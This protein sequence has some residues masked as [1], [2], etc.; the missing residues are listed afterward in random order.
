MSKPH[1]RL[2]CSLSVSASVSVSVSVCLSLHVSAVCHR[3]VQL[4]AVTTDWRVAAS[5][6]SRNPRVFFA[7]FGATPSHARDKQ[8]SQNW[9]G[10]RRQRLGMTVSHLPGVWGNVCSVLLMLNARCVR[11][12]YRRGYDT[13]TERRP[14]QLIT[15]ISR[16]SGDQR[17]THITGHNRSESVRRSEWR[18]A[19]SC[20]WWRRMDV[21]HAYTQARPHYNLLKRTRCNRRNSA[22]DETP[23]HSICCEFVVQHAVEQ[24]ARQIESLSTANL[25]QVVQHFTLTRDSRLSCGENPESL[26]YLGL[27]RYRVVTP[28]QTDR[29]AENYLSST[30]WFC[31]ERKNRRRTT[32]GRYMS[33]RCTAC[34]TTCCPT[35]HSKS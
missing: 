8:R 24:A 5:L 31:W 1:C 7:Q 9:S 17:K 26:S 10:D 20:A 32:N 14:S 25:Q 18:D 19:L 15:H 21:V 6:C 2:S 22:T 3:V 29:R 4:F 16:H 27:V 34:C 23:L 12:L 28:G 30:C 35:N 33:R 13:V 11:T